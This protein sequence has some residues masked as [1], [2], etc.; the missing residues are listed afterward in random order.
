MENCSFIELYDKIWAN[1][2]LF[3]FSLFSSHFKA[4]AATS[5]QQV[6][7]D[8]HLCSISY[9]FFLAFIEFIIFTK[10]KEFLQIF[11]SLASLCFLLNFEYTYVLLCDTMSQGMKFLFLL[12]V[13]PFA[14]FFLYCS[15]LNNFFYNVFKFT[16]FSP[17]VSDL[18]LI[19]SYEF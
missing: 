9:L 18:K 17:I 16:H 4:F 13:F 1:F 10:F 6:D 8:V 15:N 3:W 2:L 7:N 19:L 12:S 11:Y 14:L 5:F